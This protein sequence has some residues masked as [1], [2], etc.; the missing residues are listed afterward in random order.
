MNYRTTIVLLIVLALVLGIGYVYTGS[1]ASRG[2]E[3]V[4]LPQ[5]Q[6]YLVDLED[7]QRLEVDYRGKKENFFKDAEGTWRFDTAAK[8]PV[9]MNR[10]GGITLLVSGPRYE[11]VISTQATD[12]ARYGLQDPPLTVKA[13]MKDL[14]RITIRVGDKTPDGQNAYAIFQD[15]RAIHLIASDWGDV[16]GR[17]VTE[18]PMTTPTPAGAN[19]VPATNPGF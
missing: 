3:K 9:N 5:E 6:F 12:L 18:P 8:P 19:P 2:P 13:D 11:R 15:E 1:R 10:W 4:S 16:I 17:L 7:I 14:G